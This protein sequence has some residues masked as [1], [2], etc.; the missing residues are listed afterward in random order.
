MMSNQGVKNW[1]EEEI[2][3]D[4]KQEIISLHSSG[5]SQSKIAETLNL[6]GK[7]RNSGL[8]FNQ[9]YISLVLTNTGYRAKDKK[10]GKSEMKKDN[11]VIEV[12]DNI[13]F[14][15][16]NKLFTNSLYVAKVFEKNHKNVLQSIENLEC[17]IK[18]RS[19]EFSADLF[20]DKYNRDQKCYLMT[21][22]GFS[23]L[24]FGFTGSK[25]IEFK[26]KYLDKF[27]EMRSI[28][29]TK[30]LPQSKVID[31]PSYSETLRLYADEMDAR[32]AAEKLATERKE[33]LLLSEK[34]N[35]ELKDTNLKLKSEVTR[36]SKTIRVLTTVA[37]AWK[38]FKDKAP[39]ELYSIEHIV[40]Q[41]G[42]QGLV[43]KNQLLA[44]MRKKNILKSDI[45]EK[46]LDDGKTKTYYGESHNLPYAQFTKYITIRK[47]HDKS[48]KYSSNVVYVYRKGIAFIMKV[49]DTYVQETQNILPLF[50]NLEKEG[51]ENIELSDDDMQFVENMN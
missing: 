13:V 33:Q 20:K 7:K 32:T 34:A 38:E 27:E 11:E 41:F 39:D 50:K 31:L 19:A 40:L 17:S 3:N 46:L 29:I 6:A 9:G 14:E 12:D 35:N 8:K 24:A 36:V 23:L 2:T 25:A 42:Y 4:I 28:L 30:S 26:E 47:S 21:E 15:K 45:S 16:E 49:I 44:F 48:L 18:F 1:I 51:Y 5:V 22:K 10:K 37:R 43:G